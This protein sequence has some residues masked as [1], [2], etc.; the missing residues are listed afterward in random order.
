MH[1]MELCHACSTAKNDFDGNYD[2]KLYTSTAM[3][4]TRSD[5]REGLHSRVSL[6]RLCYKY[7]QHYALAISW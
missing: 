5:I 1:V 4:V 2:G 6:A 3:R 7:H